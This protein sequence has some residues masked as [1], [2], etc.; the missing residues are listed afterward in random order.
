M[1]LKNLSPFF[2]FWRT[3][4]ALDREVV[5]AVVAPEHHGPT[6]EL[7]DALES[8]P[9][10]FYWADE[11]RKRLMLIRSLRPNP[12]ERWWLH[13]LLFLVTFATV[14]MAGALL[15]GP[16]QQ[17]GSILSGDMIATAHAAWAWIEQTMPATTFAVAVMGILLVHELG[18]YVMA[19]RYHINAS[20]PYFLPSPP[21]INL[22]GTFGAFIRLRS[23][24][25][26]R[27]QLL[28][29]GAAG[30]WAGLVISIVALGLGL[31]QSTILS[32]VHGDSAQLVY[33]GNG[34]FPFFLG[35]SLLMAVARD[36]FLGE[37][38]VLLHPFAVAG[39]FGLLI[40]A[41]NLMP[42]GQLDG[43]HIMYSLL[44]K[45][46]SVVAYVTWA[47]LVVL[48]FQFKGWWLWAALI[49]LLGRGRI[50]HPSVMDPHQPVPR[51]RWPVGIASAILFVATMSPDPFPSFP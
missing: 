43:G 18:H 48:G 10:T 44:G 33:I 38:T 25:I 51:N 5:D 8:W 3:S 21:S 22:I 16:F 50:G 40:T 19:R 36:W 12:R 46:Q 20:P 32:G 45:G 9:G 27:R 41:I 14:W 6:T 47:G 28:D 30:P 29:V 35:D 2:A 39:W 42:L 34:Q 13:G 37:G 17:P 49:L 24:I 26:D 7:N 23:P 15:V 4:V 11:S 1:P 31:P